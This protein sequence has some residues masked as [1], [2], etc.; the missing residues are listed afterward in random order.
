[1]TVAEACKTLI[2]SWPYRPSYVVSV[3][4]GAD[5]ISVFLLRELYDFEDAIPDEWEGYPVVK[6]VTG[7]IILA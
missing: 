3:G 4:A 1:M 6:K 2:A 5:F 7:P